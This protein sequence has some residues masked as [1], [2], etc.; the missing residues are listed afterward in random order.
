MIPNKRKYIGTFSFYTF[1]STFQMNFLPSSRFKWRKII[2][3]FLHWPFNHWRR[4][5]D[6]PKCPFIRIKSQRSSKYSFVSNHLYIYIYI[7]LDCLPFN[8]QL[9]KAPFKYKIW[10]AGNTWPLTLN[11]SPTSFLLLAHIHFYPLIYLFYL[12]ILD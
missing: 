3:Y 11:A 12:L 8:H 2:T 9:L 7:S 1:E 10:K 4:R 5:E 6:H